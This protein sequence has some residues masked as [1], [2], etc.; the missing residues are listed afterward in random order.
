MPTI[1]NSSKPSTQSVLPAASAEKGETTQ[2]NVR[3]GKRLH[4]D[5]V[6][7]LASIGINPSEAVRALW[8]KAARRGKDLAEVRR[9]LAG[10]VEHPDVDKN[11]AAVRAGQQIVEQRAAQLGLD[12][13]SLPLDGFPSYDEIAEEA[14][15]EALV[16]AG[17]LNG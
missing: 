6:K 10:A 14:R 13:V 2:M 12:V 7:A 17:V 1:A 9:V 5:G 4:E 3:M 8:A 15:L 11:V 16:Q